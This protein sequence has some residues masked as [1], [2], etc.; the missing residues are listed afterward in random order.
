MITTLQQ[1]VNITWQHEGYD[2]GK[3]SRWIR[4]LLV[5]ALTPKGETAEQLFDQTASIVR[6]TRKVCVFLR[7]GIYFTA[8][9][10]NATIA[11]HGIPT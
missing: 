9:L 10:D 1:I 7:P 2:I 8:D 5:L 4:C 11:I 3:L 6:E